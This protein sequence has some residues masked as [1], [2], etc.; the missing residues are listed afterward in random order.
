MESEHLGPEQLD[1]F[2]DGTSEDVARVR[3]HL[4]GCPTCSEELKYQARADMLLAEAVA[5]GSLNTKPG[6][7][8]LPLPR[9]RLS[10]RRRL[11]PPLPQPASPSPPPAAAVV[12]PP[13]S[14][15][16]AA[17]AATPQPAPAPKARAAAQPPLEMF[18]SVLHGRKQ[19]SQRALGGGVSIALHALVLGTVA[20]IS[21]RPPKVVEAPKGVAVAFVAKAGGGAPPPPPLHP[22]RLRTTSRIRT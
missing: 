16:S 14:A 6:A 18:G 19:G 21:S 12:P 1:A 7:A 11:Q 2:L 8:R 9:Q 17:S 10:P 22:R 5:N 3:S 20:Y 13:A 15:V 4:A